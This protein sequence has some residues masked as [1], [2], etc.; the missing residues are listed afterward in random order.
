MLS[1]W[2]NLLLSRKTVEL[3]L[4]AYQM[5]RRIRM[6]PR[7]SALQSA[8]SCMKIFSWKI[9]QDAAQ[10]AT[11]CIEQLGVRKASTV[12]YT[13]EMSDIRR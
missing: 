1:S 4:T 6:S 12:P 11:G 2:H 5:L 13:P 8:L 7:D 3:S 9:Q 10:V